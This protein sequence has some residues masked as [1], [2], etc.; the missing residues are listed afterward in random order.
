MKKIYKIL[1]AVLFVF[2]TGIVKA[3]F[4]DVNTAQDAAI[5]NDALKDLQANDEAGEYLK[6]QDAAEKKR[7]AAVKKQRAE[8]KFLQDND[9]EGEYIL[10]KNFPEEY[11]EIIKYK[12]L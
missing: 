11:K 2:S 9:E 7:A 6:Q 5:K 4:V 8:F 12:M 10:N 1:L 3:D